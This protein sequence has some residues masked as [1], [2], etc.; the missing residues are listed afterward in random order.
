MSLH[1]IRIRTFDDTEQEYFIDVT[2]PEFDFQ[3]S[4][5]SVT[6][7]INDEIFRFNKSD[8]FTLFGLDLIIRSIKIYNLNYLS[9]E[10]LKLRFVIG[11]KRAPKIIYIYKIK[12]IEEYE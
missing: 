6:F 3:G 8:I 9:K 12:E 5:M 4:V 11:D 10:I 7:K 2:L 1:K